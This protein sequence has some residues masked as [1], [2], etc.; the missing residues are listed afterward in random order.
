MLDWYITHVYVLPWWAYVV[1]LYPCGFAATFHLVENKGADF[2][3][4]LFWPLFVFVALPLLYS[5]WA[6]GWLVGLTDKTPF[7]F[8]E[9][10]Y[11]E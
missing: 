3:L 1:M 8:S 2:P 11:I 9:G 6:F 7:S 5:G 4:A 10:G